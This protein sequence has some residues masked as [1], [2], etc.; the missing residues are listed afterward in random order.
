MGKGWGDVD[1]INDEK[2][3]AREENNPWGGDPGT[4]ESV[5]PT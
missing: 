3:E 4:W 2:A 1:E 5:P